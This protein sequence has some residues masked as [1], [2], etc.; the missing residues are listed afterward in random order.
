MKKD[1]LGGI[2]PLVA[3]FFNTTHNTVMNKC[4][5]TTKKEAILQGAKI[6]LLQFFI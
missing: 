5:H 3:T 2:V 6:C 1:P 4:T